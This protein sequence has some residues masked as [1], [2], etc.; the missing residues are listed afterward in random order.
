MRE[1]DEA[2]VFSLSE[3]LAHTV[4]GDLDRDVRACGVVGNELFGGGAIAEDFAAVVVEAKCLY[5]AGDRVLANVLDG[6]MT[7]LHDEEI[8]VFDNGIKLA[9]LGNVAREYEALALRLD[10]EGVGV[11]AVGAV[12]FHVAVMYRANADALVLEEQTVGVKLVLDEV[13]EIFRI[14]RNL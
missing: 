13:E 6:V 8:A 11:P 3:K 2:V 7:R 14:I 5:T 4:V 10:K 9:G 12:L 1:A